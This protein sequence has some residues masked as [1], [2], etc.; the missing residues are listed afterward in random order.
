[1]A[2]DVSHLSDE[3]FWDVMDITSGPVCASH[4]NSRRVYPVSRNLTDEMFRAICQTGGV[5]GLN[6]YTGFLGEEPVTLEA[7][8]RHVLHWLELDGGKHIA[9]GGDLDGCERLPEGLG[10]V[11]DYP[12]LARALADHGVPQPVLEDLFWNN[13]MRVMESC[14]M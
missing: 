12:A 13:G 14:S 8:C 9:L 5:A 7:A 11:D 3:G 10:G 2:L 6:L 4:S 1:M